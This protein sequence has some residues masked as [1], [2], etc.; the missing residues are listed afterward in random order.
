[1]ET[2]NNIGK[3]GHAKC[4]GGDGCYEKGTPMKKW[5]RL[6]QFK[7]CFMDATTFTD[8]FPED[9]KELRAVVAKRYTTPVSPDDIAI[10]GSGADYVDYSVTFHLSCT[11]Q[12]LTET[13]DEL[14]K[15]EAR[16]I[17]VFSVLDEAGNVVLTEETYGN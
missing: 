14:L 5:E 15:K 12:D 6:E 3:C 10:E 13:V 16:A 9:D 4:A 7:L 1:M 2:D 17:D 8:E 11:R